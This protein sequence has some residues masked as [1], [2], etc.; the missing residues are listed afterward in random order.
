M[1]ARELRPMDQRHI[2]TLHSASGYAFRFPALDSPLIEAGVGIEG[3]AGLIAAAVAV[4]Q[5]EVMLAL[6]KG[7]HPLMKLRALA[8]VHDEMRARLAARGYESAFC[9][10]P[11]ELV[12]TYGRHLEKI[13]NWRPTWQGYVI[14]KEAQGA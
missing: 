6:S 4:R 9:F 8:M 11:P 7:G 5:P 12:R 14:G 3:D 10:L 1:R 13:F 2:E